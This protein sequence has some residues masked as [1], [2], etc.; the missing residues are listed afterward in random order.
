MFANGRSEVSDLFRRWLV[1]EQQVALD[2][3]EYA[4]LNTAN[5]RHLAVA[6][7]AIFLVAYRLVRLRYFL[8]L[9]KTILLPSKVVPYLGFLADSSRHVVCLKPGKEREI[10]AICP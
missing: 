9:Q 2:K 7:S 4:T 8:G 6:R 5:D 10:S 3:G 1:G